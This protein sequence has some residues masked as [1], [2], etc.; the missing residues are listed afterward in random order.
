MKFGIFGMGAI[1]HVL[2]QSLWHH[3]DDL[4]FFNRSQK[5]EFRFKYEKI[6]I[7]KPIDVIAT[8]QPMNSL[9]WLVICLKEYHYKR[10]IPWLQKLIS[11]NTKVVIVR[12]GLDLKDPLLPYFNPSQILET[13][14]DA[15]TQMNSDGFYEMLRSP[16]L[17]LP[18]IS[19]AA[20]FQ[21]LINQDFLSV[22]LVADFKT[23]QWEKL[24]ESA[25]LGALLALSGETCWIFEDE[26]VVA[27]YAQLIEEAIQV[28]QKDGAL[29]DSNFK[30]EL[31]EKAKKYPPEKGSSMLTDR[32]SGRPIEI[33]VKSG[34]IS[35]LGRRYQIETPL[36]DLVSL[37]LSKTNTSK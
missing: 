34:A 33:N 4:V 5:D 26:K 36:H 35:R 29:I 30:I 1:G 24:I 20:E 10:A 11:A 16:K 21:K 2:A 37:I 32:L 3:R 9:D 14:I 13:I 18:D 12:N 6:I 15:P 23:K 19:L 28:A 7:E 8:S 27:L 17:L 25:S 22:Q 31:I